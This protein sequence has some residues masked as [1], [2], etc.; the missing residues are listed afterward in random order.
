MRPSLLSLSTEKNRYLTG[1]KLNGEVWLLNDSDEKLD[2]VAL[3]VF[4]VADGVRACIA[5]VGALSASA[6]D[7]TRGEHFELMISEELSERF[8]IEL[9]SK[10][11][12]E[13]SS[14]YNFVHNKVF[15]ACRH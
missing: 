5:K 11:H 7:N 8:S 4:L 15:Y 12:P 3:E 13:L 9:V 10:T 2:D 14:V 1:E 6:R